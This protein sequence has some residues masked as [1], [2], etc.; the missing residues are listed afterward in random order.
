VIMRK[1][2][3]I[4]LFKGL[5]GWL[6]KFFPTSFPDYEGLECYAGVVTTHPE[7]R[8]DPTIQFEQLL[9][10]G[11]RCIAC[12]FSST[13]DQLFGEEEEIWLIAT[14][15]MDGVRSGIRC[16]FATTFLDSPR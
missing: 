10:T 15:W 16:V 3:P 2:S 8:L 4:S 12:T 14:K 6:C 9:L 11:G 13:V 7:R 5:L 1:G